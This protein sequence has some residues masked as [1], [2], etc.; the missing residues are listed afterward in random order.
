MDLRSGEILGGTTS[1]HWYQLG[2]LAATRCPWRSE[3]H[4]ITKHPDNGVAI[5][6]QFI[7]QMD[8]IREIV[9]HAHMSMCPGVP[10]IGWDVALTREAGICLLEANLSCNFFRATFDEDAYYSFVGR[11]FSVLEREAAK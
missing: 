6:G 7:P 9:A 3:N 5:A 4:T 11:V 10:I 8:K 1:S 2:L